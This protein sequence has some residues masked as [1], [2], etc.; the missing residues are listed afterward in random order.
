V[1]VMHTA[2]FFC[3]VLYWISLLSL[4]FAKIDGPSVRGTSL[5][6]QR[7]GLIIRS[8]NFEQY[9][10]QLAFCHRPQLFMDAWFNCGNS[11]R[12]GTNGFDRNI[13]FARCTSSWLDFSIHALSSACWNRRCRLIE[14]QPLS[15]SPLKHAINWYVR[16]VTIMLRSRLIKWAIKTL[17]GGASFGSY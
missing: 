12:I 8:L 1:S 15:T 9:L 3:F 7:L 2:V 16:Q 10:E 6:M 4:C 17:V 14:V 5:I 11:E 13:P